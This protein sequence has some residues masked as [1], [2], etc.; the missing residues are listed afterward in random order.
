MNLSFDDQ[1]R[2]AYRRMLIGGVSGVLLF[3]VPSTVYFWLNGD[4]DKSPIS[5]APPVFD[6]MLLGFL[7]AIVGVLSGLLSRNWS[8]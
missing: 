6:I 8:R 4:F 5:D 2:I 1:K 3:I 7:G